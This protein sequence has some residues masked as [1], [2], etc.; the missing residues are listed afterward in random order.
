MRLLYHGEVVLAEFCEVCPEDDVRKA[1]GNH[2][3]DYD[4]PQIVVSCCS[5]CHN[6]L[7]R[8]GGK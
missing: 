5:S 4:Y 6:Y 2:H 7:N 8:E 3:P 1:T